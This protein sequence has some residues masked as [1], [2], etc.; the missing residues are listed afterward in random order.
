MALIGFALLD[1]NNNNFFLTQQV[2]KEVLVDLGVKLWVST[3]RVGA[4]PRG[5][6][7]RV[8]KHQHKHVFLQGFHLLNSR[9]FGGGNLF[10]SRTDNNFFC[11]KG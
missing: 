3:S 2:H 10:M 4:T 6:H 5:K 7:I 9:L 11:K 1:T 8:R